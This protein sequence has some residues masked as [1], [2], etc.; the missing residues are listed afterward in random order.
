MNTNIIV[1]CQ[2]LYPCNVNSKNYSLLEYD[3]VQLGR[4]SPNLQA[5]GA[6][7]KFDA[8]DPLQILVPK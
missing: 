1:K 3:T 8:A 2:S 6:S 5:A 4:Q 7:V